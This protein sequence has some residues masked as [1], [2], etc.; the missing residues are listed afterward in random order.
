LAVKEAWALTARTRNG[1]WKDFFGLN[2]RAEGA[3][4]RREEI[5]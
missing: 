5:G 3:G 1:N 2:R 4:L